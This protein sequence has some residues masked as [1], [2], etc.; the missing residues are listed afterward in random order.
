MPV[1]KSDCSIRILS[2][3]HCPEG[4]IERGR[5][6]ADWDAIAQVEGGSNAVIG[7]G[8]ISGKA[9]AQSGCD[10]IPLIERVRIE[11]SIAATHHRVA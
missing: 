10:G 7:A 2:D 9:E 3:R 11:D 8:Q 5:D 6:R 1:E 4:V